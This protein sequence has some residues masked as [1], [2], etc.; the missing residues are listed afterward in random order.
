M[1]LALGDASDP[2]GL[3]ATTDELPRGNGLL[4]AR[5]GRALQ[6]AVWA[7]LLGLSQ[8][9]ATERNQAPAGISAAPGRLSLRA[10]APLQVTS[11]AGG[12]S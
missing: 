5:W 1:A 2:V 10:G 12:R 11:Q 7:S 8:D 6:A 3:V 9:H 4:A